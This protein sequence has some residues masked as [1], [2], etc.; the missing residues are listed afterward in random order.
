MSVTQKNSS[1][2]D[3]FGWALNAEETLANGDQQWI[4]RGPDGSTIVRDVPPLLGMEPGP[5]GVTRRIVR[6]DQPPN[7]IE[8][9]VSL[10][11]L[12]INS[13]ADRLRIF[14]ELG[15]EDKH[16]WNPKLGYIATALRLFDDDEV[17]YAA[18]ESTLR[19]V[20]PI[21]HEEWRLIALYWTGASSGKTEAR[22]LK[23]DWRK[24]QQIE[25]ANDI[26]G[27]VRLGV[28]PSEAIEL[29]NSIDDDLDLERFKAGQI[30]DALKLPEPV[31]VI[32]GML[33]EDSVGIIYGD[34]QTYKSFIAIALTIAVGV[35]GDFFGVP[36]LTGPTLFIAGEGQRAL[37]RRYFWQGE[38]MGASPDQMR[39]VCEIV[40]EMPNFIDALEFKRILTQ[41]R[42]KQPKLIVVDTFAL[43]QGDGD[44]NASGPVGVVMKNLR[45]LRDASPGSLV[46]AVDHSGKDATRGPR[47]HSRK[48]RDADFVLR[49]VRTGKDKSVMSLAKQ[50]DGASDGAWAFKFDSFDNR[51]WVT[52]DNSPMAKLGGVKEEDLRVLVQALLDEA[53]ENNGEPVKVE[54]WKKAYGLSTRGNTGAVY[55]S[56][57]RHHAE[58]EGWVERQGKSQKSPWKVTEAG[59]K[60]LFIN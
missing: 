33:M 5:G 13:K 36:C 52:L 53:A 18:V 47:G 10:L 24:R 43:A 17:T 9:E 19:H 55:V 34:E 59:E 35:T 30:E 48:T 29:L 60:F 23:E 22:V 41:V 44:E 45:R 2:T 54:D 42:K 49:V 51:V 38:Q 6:D 8:A 40:P 56:K 46:V 39:N 32:E 31:Y 50:K 25:A 28:E 12:A 4:R 7:N 14:G 26:L 20:C 1:R 58:K 37:A 27:M 15:V 57:L 11:S 3:Y 21:T 16:F